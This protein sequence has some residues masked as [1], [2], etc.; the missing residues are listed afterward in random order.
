VSRESTPEQIAKLPGHARAL[1]DRLQRELLVA[2]GRIE[3][4]EKELAGVVGDAD[5]VWYSAGWAR[6]ELERRPLPNDA[7]VIFKVGVGEVRVMIGKTRKGVEFLDINADST[8]VV[9]PRATNSVCVTHVGRF[10]DL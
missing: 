3:E 9:H 8:V 2:E 6:R 4:A 5:R 7:H 10:D 1:I